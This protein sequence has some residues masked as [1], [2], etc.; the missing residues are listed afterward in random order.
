MSETLEIRITEDVRICSPDPLN[1]TVEK[2]RV[3]Q[4]GDNKGAVQ[5]DVIGYHGR[6]WDALHSVLH[7]KINLLID[8]ASVKDLKTLLA[9]IDEAA[10][11]IMSACDRVA[12]ARKVDEGNGKGVQEIRSTAVTPG[13][14][15][16]L[17]DG[18]VQKQQGA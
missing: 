6:L 8:P 9:A 16:G 2:R 4:K 14:E 17:C 7:R 1:Y 13:G 5:W 15:E 3:V 10:F 12:A 18:P 11:H